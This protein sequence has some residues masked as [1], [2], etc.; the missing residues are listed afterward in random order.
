MSK[1][2]KS[3]ATVTR[4]AFVFLC[5]I[6]AFFV[7]VGLFHPESP[8]PDHWHPLKPLEVA[9][10]MT[11]LTAWKLD[12]TVR[13][14]EQCLEVLEDA[15]VLR[16]MS[17]KVVDDN[18]GISPRVDLSRVGKSQL[19]SIETACPT[20]L[21]LAMWEEHGVQPAAEFYLGAEVTRI[22]HAGSFSCRKIRSSS[23]NSN[24]WSSHARAMA[25]DVA[26]FDLSDGQRIR[27]INHWDGTQEQ[28]DFLRAV[29]DSACIW[30]RTTLSPDFNALHADHFHLQS[31]GRGTCR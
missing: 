2:S 7:G 27:L 23:G 1:R 20:A 16:R 22:R 26:G 19:G 15:V 5:V 11:P 24:R 12:R 31:T 10:P 4:A 3:H 29:R 30:F 28:Q 8:L 13:N 25:I 21:R 18:C 6:S 9:A 14:P 17:D